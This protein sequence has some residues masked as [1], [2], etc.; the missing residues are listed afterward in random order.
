METS[1]LFGYF[2]TAMVFIFMYA[3]FT[4]PFEEHLSYCPIATP[5]S[6]QELSGMGALTF[7]ILEQVFILDKEQK[8][9]ASPPVAKANRYPKPQSKSQEPRPEGRGM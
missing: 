7:F 8:E 1:R 4:A 5:T 2:G 3:T 9:V 6:L